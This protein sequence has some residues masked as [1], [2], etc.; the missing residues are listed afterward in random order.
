MFRSSPTIVSHCPEAGICVITVIIERY[1]VGV[2]VYYGSTSIGGLSTSIV[3]TVALSAAHRQSDSR[4]GDYSKRE[5]EK[6]HL[7]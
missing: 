3:A 4:K 5:R 1:A 7:R 6:L 2:G